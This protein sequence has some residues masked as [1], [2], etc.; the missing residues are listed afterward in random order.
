ME[1]LARSVLVQNSKQHST[2][3]MIEKYIAID[4]IVFFDLINASIA[5]SLARFTLIATFELNQSAAYPKV[6][7]RRTDFHL[8]GICVLQK[9]SPKKRHAAGML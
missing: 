3:T 9:I 8:Q 5:S 7:S 2:S 6:Y 1:P 4:D